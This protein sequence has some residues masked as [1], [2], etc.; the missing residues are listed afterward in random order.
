MLVSTIID[1]R[2]HFCSDLQPATKLDAWCVC[3]CF[4]YKH[5]HGASNSMAT[6]TLWVLYVAVVYVQ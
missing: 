6:V 2:R 5:T 4:L 3:V 1:R